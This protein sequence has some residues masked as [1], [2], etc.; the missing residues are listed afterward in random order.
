MVSGYRRKLAGSKY[1]SVLLCLV[2]IIGFFVMMGHVSP[3]YALNAGVTWDYS[4]YFLNHGAQPSVQYN[5]GDAS[6]FY[7]SGLP[8]KLVSGTDSW[9]YTF[10]YTGSNNVFKMSTYINFTSPSGTTDNTHLRVT[11]A[12]DNAGTTPDTITLKVKDITISTTQVYPNDWNTPPTVN[13]SRQPSTVQP[14][15]PAGDTMDPDGICR[16]WK[17]TTPGQL[18]ISWNGNTYH[19]GCPPSDSCGLSG[20]TEVYIQVV[21]LQD[22][23]PSQAV[24]DA[25]KSK[26]AAHQIYL[27]FFLDPEAPNHIGTIDIPNSGGTGSF[28]DYKKGLFGT[29]QERAGTNGDCNG[30][31]GSALDLCVSNILTA[32][33]MVFHFML[34]ANKQVVARGS[35]GFSEIPGNDMLVTMGMLTGG[36][37]SLDE[38]EGT[39]MHELGHNLGL[40]HGGYNSNLNCKPNYPSVMDY[41]YQLSVLV[42]RPLDYSSGSQ[43]SLVQ[44]SISESSGIGLSGWAAVYGKDP[45][46]TPQVPQSTSTATAANYNTDSQTTDVGTFRLYNVGGWT[47]CNTPDNPITHQ[48]YSMY[49]SGDWTHLTFNFRGTSGYT[50]GLGGEPEEVNASPQEIGTAYSQSIIPTVRPVDSSINVPTKDLQYDS[51]NRKT[52]QTRVKIDKTKITDAATNL[53]ISTQ[54]KIGK[55]FLDAR[56]DFKSAVADQQSDLQADNI[57]IDL[58]AKLSDVD[59]NLTNAETKVKEYLSNSVSVNRVDKNELLLNASGTIEESFDNATNAIDYYLNGKVP[60]DVRED[61]KATLKDS[62]YDL[63]GLIQSSRY[64]QKY[65]VFLEAYTDKSRL[66]GIEL[67]SSMIAGMRAGLLDGLNATIQCLDYHDKES[68]YKKLSAAKGNLSDDLLPNAIPVL[69]NIAMEIKASGEKSLPGEICKIPNPKADAL[70]QLNNINSTYHTAITSVTQG[71]K[72][73]KTIEEAFPQWVW[74]LIAGILGLVGLGIFLGYILSRAEK[75][76]KWYKDHWPTDDDSKEP[77]HKSK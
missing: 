9:T 32:K 35:T 23:L 17:T 22:Q 8:V 3:A 70:I 29:P 62:E 65:Q 75:S 51:D 40:Q 45:Q 13:T 38:Q 60:D 53:I 1:Y 58:N 24:F 27:H 77:V 46:L 43:P 31:G 73:T 16:T 49:D 11:V 4:M 72:Y 76:I 59:G 26:F 41:N 5:E 54:S 37:G 39:I 57:S 42:S 56:N 2:G 28:Y 18:T 36:Y 71:V 19:S 15:C 74:Y 66:P 14:S 44:G 21:G 34:I 10:P 25:I 48:P 20:Q 61:L 63:D 52:T 12:S 69:Q 64:D 67:N 50:S 33:K 6:S 7:S 55:E 47:G 30:L 68:L